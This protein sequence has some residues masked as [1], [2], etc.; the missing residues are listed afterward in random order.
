MNEASP[1]IQLE[2]ILINQDKWFIIYQRGLKKWEFSGESH[3]QMWFSKM[4]THNYVERFS[5]NSA[6]GVITTR[7]QRL[8]PSNIKKKSSLSNITMVTK[9]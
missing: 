1:V 8:T 4:I 5:H 9:M 7:L 2:P 3:Q 6:K